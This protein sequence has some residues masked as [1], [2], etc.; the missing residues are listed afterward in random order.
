[1]T[2]IKLI[3]SARKQIYFYCAINNNE[4]KLIAK[5]QANGMQ[6]GRQLKSNAIAVFCNPERLEG[7][8]RGREITKNKNY[9]RI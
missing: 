3:S 7:E 6:Q 4:K 2:Y 9:F 8:K 1:L 5:K